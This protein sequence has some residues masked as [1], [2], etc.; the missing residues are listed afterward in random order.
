M[1]DY[2]TA[3]SNI[4]PD[5]I[6]LNE[7]FAKYDFEFVILA[8]ILSNTDMRHRGTE[9]IKKGTF[10][11][12]DENASKQALDYLTDLFN[13][14]KRGNRYEIKYFCSEFWKFYRTNKSYN[15]AKFMAN[16]KKNKTKLESAI[17]ENGQLVKLFQSY[18]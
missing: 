10:K 3:W 11:I 6:K 2:V 12:K 14:I 18:C 9:I 7:Y 1:Q 17:V 4:N 13:V 16:V 5:F 8:S 15:H